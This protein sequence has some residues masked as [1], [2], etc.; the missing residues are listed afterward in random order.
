MRPIVISFAC[1]DFPGES[2][3]DILNYLDVTLIMGA[4]ELGIIIKNGQN[5]ALSGCED[6]HS[7]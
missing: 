2:L 1:C 7:W 6:K 4:P 5:K 3:L